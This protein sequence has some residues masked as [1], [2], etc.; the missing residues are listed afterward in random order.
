MAVSRADDFA[1]RS[2]AGVYVSAGQKWHEK[3]KWKETQTSH[4]RA[5]RK[6][7]VQRSENATRH[8]VGLYRAKS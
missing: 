3:P 5:D 2:G 1:D 6:K 8:T 7:D 4:Q